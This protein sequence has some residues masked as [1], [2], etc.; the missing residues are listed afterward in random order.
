LRNF[1]FAAT[2]NVN[3]QKFSGDISAEGCGKINGPHRVFRSIDGNQYFS[4][5]RF[6]SRHQNG[7]AFGLFQQFGGH[8]TDADTANASSAPATGDNHIVA[9]ARFFDN[10]PGNTLFSLFYRNCDII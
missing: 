2:D 3:E 6:S 9:V 1:T 4:F 10:V 7:Y 8:T 5:Q